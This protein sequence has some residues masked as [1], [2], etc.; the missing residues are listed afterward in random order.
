M[1]QIISQRPQN[2]NTNQRTAEQTHTNEN[3]NRQLPVDHFSKQKNPN[4]N[5]SVSDLP[6]LTL[7]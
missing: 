1:Q 4:E 2:R 3:R 6:V 7:K 5:H